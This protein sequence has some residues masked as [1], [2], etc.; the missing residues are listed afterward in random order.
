MTK[1]RT[2][3]GLG[4]GV[5]LIAALGLVSACSDDG[6]EPSPTTG[7]GGST[8]KGGTTSKGGSESKGGT[9]STA[10]TTSTDGGSGGTTDVGGA[11][12]NDSGGPGGAAGDGG[13][14]G[15]EDPVRV[16]LWNFSPLEE[17]PPDSTNAFADD[18]DAAAL[19]QR[20]FF[21]EKF[22]GPLKIDSDLGLIDQTGKVSCRSCHGSPLMDDDRSNPAT[23]AIGAGL[24]TRNSPAVV[25]SSF[26]AWTNWGGRFAAQWELPLA[27]VENGV[28]MNGNRLALAHRIFD[29]Y[30][31]DYEAVFGALTPEIGT[32]AAR[33]PAA[34]KPKAAAIDPDG[35]WELMAAD[36]R[37]IINRILV[38]YSKAIA[39]YMRLLVSRNAPIDQFAAG[40]DAALS[41]AAKRGVLLFDGKAQCS[42]CHTGPHFTDNGFHVL[43]VPQTGP[44]VPATDDG[45]FKDVPPLLTS[46]L[47]INSPFSDDTNTGKL[48]GLTNPMPDSFKGAFRTPG[49]RGVALTAPYMHSGQF[50]TLAEVIDFYDAGGSVTTE[51]GLLQPLGLTAEEKAD[52]LAFLNALTGEGVAPA[53][54]TDTSAP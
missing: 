48:G 44:N 47:N 42:Q 39:A 43:G 21:D 17:V 41:D 6:D 33:F 12:G 10:G 8:G 36:D 24:H 28:I 49:L 45:R 14:G 19:G 4:G 2:R 20:L 53:L 54:L 23:V 16:H 11:A 40:D 52:L 29:V 35:P 38:N 3:R 7:K 50:A 5:A 26:Y 37:T 30:K 15:A 51:A 22:S 27:V 13:S 25:N 1:F 31:A 46:T 32:D 18:P 9:T 34:G